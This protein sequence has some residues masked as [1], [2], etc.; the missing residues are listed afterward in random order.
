MLKIFKINIA[1][2]VCTVFVFRLLF[3]NIGIIP[4]LN[5]SQNNVSTSIEKKQSG[6]DTFVNTHA[7]EFQLIEI[8]E[9]ENEN[10]EDDLSKTKPFFLI[11][12]VYSALSNKFNDLKST[13]LFDCLNYKLSSKKYLAISVLRI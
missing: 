10:D 1:V 6:K 4:S 11:S 2:L 8:C 3:V 5:S 13:D 9:E 7:N 12:Y